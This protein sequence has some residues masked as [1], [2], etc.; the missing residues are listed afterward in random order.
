MERGYAKVKGSLPADAKAYAMWQAWFEYVTAHAPA[1]VTLATAADPD[2]WREID[3]AGAEQP[4][5]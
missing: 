2:G 4:E 1:K 5:F 3:A